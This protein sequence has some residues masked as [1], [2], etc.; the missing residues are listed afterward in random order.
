MFGKLFGKLKK[1][2]QRHRK[3]EECVKKVYWVYGDPE[4]YAE[5]EKKKI[6]VYQ[7]MQNAEE[8]TRIRREMLREFLIRRGVWV[9]PR[10]KPL[11]SWITEEAANYRHQQW[12]ARWVPGNLYPDLTE[13]E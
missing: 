9:P 13:F 8:A 11:P 3:T 5:K 6:R 10:L 12:G 4:T 1:R 2:F 7:E